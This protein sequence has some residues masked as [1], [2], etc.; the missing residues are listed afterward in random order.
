MIQLNEQIPT[1]SVARSNHGKM[2]I[3]V[4]LG[5]ALLLVLLNFAD[6]RLARSN[7][8]TDANL[9]T[10]RSGESMP[11]NMTPGFDLNYQ[12]PG[13]GA[14]ATAVSAALA[15]PLSAKQVGQATAVTDINAAAAPRL[16]V[17]VDVVRRLWTPVYGRGEVTATVYFASH[18]TV[19]W[20]AD[21]AMV[22]TENPEIQ[23]TGSYTVVDTT[24]GLLSKPAYNRMLAETLA[25]AIAEGLQRDVWQRP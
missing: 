3:G 7:T 1:E 4:L 10:A 11:A 6:F 8:S 22:L 16:L 24:W 19:P 23:A 15:E 14:L 12:V 13:E 2:L 17:Q 21:S 5:A 25:T 18:H 20:N 9:G